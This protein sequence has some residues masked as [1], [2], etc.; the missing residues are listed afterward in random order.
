MIAPE[1][2]RSGRGLMGQEHLPAAGM[3]MPGGKL[4]EEGTEESIEK[5]GR[6]SNM[7]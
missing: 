2:K 6:E 3:G 7:G 4:A 5:V 1:T